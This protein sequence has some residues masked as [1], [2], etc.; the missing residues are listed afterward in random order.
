MKTITVVAKGPSAANADRYIAEHPGTHIAC[1]ND[2]FKLVRDTHKIEYCFF[3]HIE[4]AHMIAG[5]ADRFGNVVCPNLMRHENKPPPL[6]I[7]D[8]LIEYEARECAGSVEDLVA[9]IAEG[10]ITHHNTT[11]GALHWLAKH[12]KYQKIRVIGVDGGRSYTPGVGVVSDETHRLIVKNEG[13]EDYFD[14]WKD[15]TVTL[16]GVLGRIYGVEIEWYGD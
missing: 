13:T 5:V 10:E 3:T 7:V 6:G 16:C 11:N 1:I 15:V 9:K 2:S 8:K 12:G 4:F 14:I